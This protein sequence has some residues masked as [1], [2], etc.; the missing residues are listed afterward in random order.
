MDRVFC[1]HGYKMA[2]ILGD[3]EI[4]SFCYF[5]KLL[6]FFP[7]Q[8]GTQREPCRAGS[9]GRLTGMVRKVVQFLR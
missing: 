9:K 3:E 7:K 8:P 2:E 4:Y 1:V 5:R 6:R